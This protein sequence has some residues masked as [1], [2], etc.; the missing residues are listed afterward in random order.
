MVAVA[1]DAVMVVRSREVGYS[2]SEG[3][4]DASGRSAAKLFRVGGG[5]GV[6]ARTT[7]LWGGV[8]RC[9]GAVVTSMKP[10]VSSNEDGVKRDG[11]PS[12]FGLPSLLE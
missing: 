4:G 5:G 2:S 8:V 3:V 10:A 11:L 7:A 9:P 6:S 1:G 12:L